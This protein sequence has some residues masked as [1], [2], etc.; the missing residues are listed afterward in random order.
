MREKK[1]VLLEM[2][3]GLVHK[4]PQLDVDVMMCSEGLTRVETTLIPSYSD[5]FRVSGTLLEMV[6]VA[7]VLWRH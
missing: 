1:R 7:T 5:I 4:R 6:I 3:L 2:L